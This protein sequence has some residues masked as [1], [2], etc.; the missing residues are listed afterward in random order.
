[1]AAVVAGESLGFEVF[2]A[3]EQLILATRETHGRTDCC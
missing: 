1:M 3:A 2:S